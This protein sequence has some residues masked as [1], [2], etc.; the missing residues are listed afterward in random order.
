VVN[1]PKAASRGPEFL[2]RLRAFLR[3][4]AAR[5]FVV[6]DHFLDDEA[7]EFLGKFG[8]QVGFFRQLAQAG[9][10][11]RLAVGIGRGQGGPRLVLA[12][13]LRDAKPLGQNMDQ[14]GIDI[15]DALAKAREHRIGLACGIGRGLRLLR[16][17]ARN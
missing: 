15:V 5:L 13:R 7:Q 12:H 4:A 9:D 17:S 2:T 6:A 10:L 3:L 8:I 16:H 14:G 1:A 11:A